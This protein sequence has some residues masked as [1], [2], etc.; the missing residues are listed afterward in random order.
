MTCLSSFS[1]QP[2]LL[3]SHLSLP[4]K[5]FQYKLVSASPMI[6]APSRLIASLIK[7]FFGWSALGGMSL[8]L[9][10]LSLIWPSWIVPGKSP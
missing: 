9:A 6:E 3:S 8:I 7:E 2:L 10:K 5:I 4:C 1:H